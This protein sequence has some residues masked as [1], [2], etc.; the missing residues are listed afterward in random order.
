[1]KEYILSFIIAYLIGS[2][3]SAYLIG[4]IFFKKDIREYGSRNTGATN[5]LR[6]FGK[7]V[8]IITLFFDLFKAVLSLYFIDS[9]FGNQIA[10]Y[11]AAIG[12]V[13]GHNFPIYFSFKGGKGIASSAG[14]LLYFNR[15][16]FL[17]CLLTFLLVVVLS[18][19]VSLGSIISSFL[20]P[21]YG[22]LLTKDLNFT[23]T[24]FILAILAIL[25]HKKNIIR[26]LNHSENKLSL[27]GKS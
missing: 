27:G 15:Y 26:I 5:A 3:I 10:T 7:K 18:R 19:M 23:L 14:V 22:Y 25:R 1:M 13:I 12:V 6:V 24:L 11:I 9:I 20:A 8:A 2:F 17:L 16:V 21:V 4:K